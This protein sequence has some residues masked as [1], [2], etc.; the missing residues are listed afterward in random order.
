MAAKKKK[1]FEESLIELE[2]I[3]DA[4]E[5]EE[6]PLEQAVRLYKQGAKLSA[7]CQE[8]LLQIEGEIIVL[9]GEVDDMKE[10]AFIE[11]VDHD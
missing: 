6:L 7:V 9:Q 3:V 5:Q 2:E 4:L 1:T 8:Q 10:S 11:E